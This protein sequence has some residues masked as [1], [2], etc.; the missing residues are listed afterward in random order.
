[1]RRPL[2]EVAWKSGAAPIC[3]Q[4]KIRDPPAQPTEGNETATIFRFASSIP[5]KAP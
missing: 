3:Q 4:S 2:W 1:M 5:S